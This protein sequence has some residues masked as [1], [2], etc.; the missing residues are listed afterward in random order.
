M[1]SIFRIPSDRLIE[2]LD[3]AVPSKPVITVDQVNSRSISLHCATLKKHSNIVRFNV[4]LDGTIVGRGDR[5]DTFIMLS[6]LKPKTIY[7]VRIIAFSSQQFAETSFEMLIK[8]LDESTE[9]TVLEPKC[10]SIKFI[11]S[12]SMWKINYRNGEIKKTNAFEN[13]K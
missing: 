12:L 13:S 1:V 7:S 9:K 10:K 8:T 2:W 6:N 3:V 11:S 5:R 4:I